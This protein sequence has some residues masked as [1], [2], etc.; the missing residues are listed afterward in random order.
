M[1]DAPFLAVTD[2]SKHF[3]GV[4]ALTGITLE[5]RAGEVLGLVGENGAG[6]STL[7]KILT[8]IHRPDSGEMRLAGARYM[9]DGPQA[10][11]AAGVAAIQQEPLMFETL[12]VAENILIGAQPRRGRRG[13]IDWAE[14]RR[15][16]RHVLDR[17]GARIEP[18]TP[19]RALSVAERHLVALA[20][21]LSQE[22]RLIIFDEPTAALSQAEIRH[23]Y[24]IIEGLRDAG[25]AVIFISHKF[26]E[27]F[28]ICDRY[29]VLRD[30]ASVG[31]GP[32]RGTDEAALIRLMVGR[33]LSEIYPKTEV[34]IGAPVL[35]V[36]GLS[37]PTE[38]DDITFTLRRREILGFYGLVGAGRSEA[39]EAL[40][41]LK[42]EASGEIV[43]DAA[44]AAIDSP[45]AAMAAGLAY[46]PEDRQAH[47]ALLPLSIADNIALP[48]LGRLS[49]AMIDR[50][51]R[52]RALAERY[53][54]R[55]EVKAASWRQAVAELSGGN[56]QK[57]VLAKWLAT[58]PRIVILDEPTR[59][60]DV[61][62]KATVHRDIGALVAD[63]LS[64]I[65][66]SSELEEVLGIAARLIVMHRGRIAARFERSEF[67]SDA[68]MAAAT[69]AALAGAA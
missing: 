25:A 55:A 46:L 33:E 22:A 52:V 59:G 50:P 17:I 15:R 51:G 8:G 64:V 44:P 56:Q 66:V 21:A 69:G 2:V 48:V 45:A 13:P 53:A 57:V 34:A 11:A 37:H 6:K 54:R 14:M 47:G 9:P 30:G 12:S 67:S 41:G 27:I 18:E 20:R 58:E 43:I 35:E 4:H 1:A 38:F 60:I 65:L 24:G 49:P 16:A 62:T 36:R 29:A 61:G 68:V 32:I 42:P 7:V 3:G 63:G 31:A 5:A 39:M 40:F 19:L 23:L 10:A 28:R 26:D